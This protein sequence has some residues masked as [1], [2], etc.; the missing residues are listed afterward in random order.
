MQPKLVR[1]TRARGTRPAEPAPAE[2]A[3]KYVVR[4]CRV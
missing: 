4:I 2:P 1:G 3:L